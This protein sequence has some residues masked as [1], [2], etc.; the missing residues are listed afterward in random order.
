M[1]IATVIILTNLDVINCVI[2]SGD[3]KNS[4]TLDSLSPNLFKSFL[5]IFATSFSNFLYDPWYFLLKY[6]CFKAKISVLA[7]SS[8]EGNRFQN[9]SFALAANNFFCMWKSGTRLL[10]LGLEKIE[11]PCVVGILHGWW[12]STSD[13]YQIDY[14]L[15]WDKF[16]FSTE[17]WVRKIW[18]TMQGDIVWKSLEMTRLYDE[19]VLPDCMTKLYD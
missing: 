12:C 8:E 6:S 18:T 15:R 5:N 1:L 11:F 14:D 9:L 13:E 4:T 19:T 16:D 3:F 17:V 2:N 10:E 7:S